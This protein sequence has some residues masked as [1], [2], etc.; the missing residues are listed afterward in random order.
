MCM[1][2]SFFFSSEEDSVR[3]EIQHQVYR[4][5]QSVIDKRLMFQFLQHSNT[6]KYQ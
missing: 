4:L 2:L 6:Q 5:T 1:Y 3:H